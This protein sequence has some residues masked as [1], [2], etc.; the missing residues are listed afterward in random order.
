MRPGAAAPRTL[1]EVEMRLIEYRV[2][3]VGRY[4]VTRFEDGREDGPAKCWVETLGEYENGA[5]AYEVAYALCKAE[6]DRLG[7]P[8]DDSRIVYPNIPGGV[9]VAPRGSVRMEV[10]PS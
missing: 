3:P 10:T 2:R 5:V 6:H 4:I 8:V 1:M 7:W 9:S